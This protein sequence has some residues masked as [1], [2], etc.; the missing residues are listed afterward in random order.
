MVHVDRNGQGEKGEGCQEQQV[1]QGEKGLKNV[2]TSHKQQV[3][4][5]EK[6]LE[7]VS[8]SHAR[9]QSQLHA[10]LAGCRSRSNRVGCKHAL[11]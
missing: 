11:S 8:T 7:N 6:G 3:I 10:C 5:G 9:A 2:S 4:Q 1:I